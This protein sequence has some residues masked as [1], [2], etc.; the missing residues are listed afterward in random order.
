MFCKYYVAT[1]PREKTWFVTGNLR[2]HENLAFE[3]ALDAQS[4]LFEFF[5]P[6]LMEKEFLHMMSYL[7]KQGYVVDLKERKNRFQ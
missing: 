5:V 2:S 7:Q 1:I 3:R 6:P 4:G